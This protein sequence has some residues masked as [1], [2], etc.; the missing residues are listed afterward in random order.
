M[1]T[2]IQKTKKPIG[3]ALFFIISRS[4]FKAADRLNRFFIEKRPIVQK[5]SNQLS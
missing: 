2:N 1:T 5:L 4:I 3:G